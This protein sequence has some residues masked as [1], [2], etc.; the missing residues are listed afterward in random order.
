MTLSPLH[1]QT[2]LAVARDAIR[3]TL[4]GDPPDETGADE[5]IADPLLAQH[6][7]CFV[8]LHRRR[9]HALRGCVGRLDA[10]DPLLHTVRRA[11]VGVLRDPR[12]HDNPV[13]YGELPEL[14][15]DISVLSPLRPAAAPL[16]FD[17]LIDGVYLTWGEKA[18]CFLPQVARETGWTKHQLLARLCVEKM[19]LPPG[20]WQDTHAKLFV[21]TT[22]IVGPEPFERRS[23]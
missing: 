15:I 9:T 18:G 8:T 14:E 12:F 2:L 21:F 4:R 6:A 13:R 1:C 23:G 16:E 19:G 20:A 7:G 3:R 22:I 10:T 5:P 17:L 11:A